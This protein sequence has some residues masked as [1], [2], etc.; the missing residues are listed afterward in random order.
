MYIDDLNLI[1][2]LKKFTKTTNYLKEE[3][4]MKDLGKTK[5]CHGP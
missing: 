3:L 4:E 1:V 5:F 2:T